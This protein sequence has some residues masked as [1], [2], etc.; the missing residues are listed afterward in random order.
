[1]V[2]VFVLFDSLSTLSDNA[3]AFK[4]SLSTVF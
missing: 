4:V 3:D 2:A 1:M